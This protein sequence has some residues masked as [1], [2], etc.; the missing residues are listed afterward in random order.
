MASLNKV[1]LIGRLGKDP[2][3][4]TFDNGGKVCNFSLATTE[5]FTDRE[6]NKKEITD[7]H[8]IKVTGSLAGVCEKYLKKGSL[9]YVEGSLK[10]RSWE[11]NGEKRYITEV[12]VFSMQMLGRKGDSDSSSDSSYSDSTGPFQGGAETSD[13]LPF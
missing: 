3:S 9:V 11:S 12:N 4:K 2:E 5:K 8:N 13:D 10:T 7:W 1:Q 6:G